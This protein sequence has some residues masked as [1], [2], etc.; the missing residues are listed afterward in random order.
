MSNRKNAT[1]A[2]RLWR[3]IRKKTF[4]EA[5]DSG[6]GLDVIGRD[7]SPVFFWRPHEIGWR[8]VGMSTTR[9]GLRYWNQPSRILVHAEFWQIHV[10]AEAA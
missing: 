8:I 2:Q 6:H 9:R 1:R 5:W 3:A 4:A 10:A 7:G